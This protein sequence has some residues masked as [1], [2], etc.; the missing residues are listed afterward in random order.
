MA[1]RRRSFRG[2]TEVALGAFPDLNRSVTVMDVAVG[3]GAGYAASQI[4][5]GA[6]AKFAPSVAA[7]AEGMLG[8]FMPLASGLATGAIAYYAQ[9]KSGRAYGHA[10]GAAIAGLVGTVKEFVAGQ[11][12]FG[13]PLSGWGEVTEVRL[14]GMNNYRGL[15][16]PDHSDHLGGLLVTDNT[17]NR[18]NELG[19][20]SM[21][22]DDDGIAALVG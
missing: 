1:R 14:G 19:A 21:G 8:K 4:V 5:R 22:D 15:L 10:V 7:Q 20:M 11:N 13:F 16:V 3:A 6:L 18:L 17:E 2:I 9:G 12:L